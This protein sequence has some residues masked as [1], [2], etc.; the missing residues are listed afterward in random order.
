M[1]ADVT[2]DQLRTFI[3]ADTEGEASADELKGEASSRDCHQYL[4][5]A[6]ALS[7]GGTIMRSAGS[8]R[9]DYSGGERP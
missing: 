3:A 1:L 4:S 7:I 6:G 2:L 9:S 5:E 8:V